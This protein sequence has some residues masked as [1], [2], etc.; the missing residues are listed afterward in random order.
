MSAGGAHGMAQTFRNTRDCLAQNSDIIESFIHIL[1]DIRSHFHH[2]LV[3]LRLHFVFDHF[4]SFMNN[5]LFMTF[6]LSCFRIEYHVFL[7]DA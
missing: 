6:K 5:L 7:L 1:A 3:H 4:L 2:R